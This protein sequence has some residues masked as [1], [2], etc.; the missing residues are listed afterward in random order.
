MDRQIVPQLTSL[1]YVNTRRNR[2]IE[3]RE[4][5]PF[6]FVVTH[7]HR[8]KGT[9]VKGKPKVSFAIP[10]LNRERTLDACLRSIADQDY[11]RTEIIIVDGG[12]T[13]S[14]LKIASKY[15]SKIIHNDGPLGEARQVGVENSNGDIVAIFDSDII[16]PSKNWLAD[17]VQKFHESE[18]VG[19]VWPVNKAPENA[20]V[21]S[22]CYFA[23]WRTRASVFNNSTN[24]RLI[25]G[26]NS[27]VL[28]EALENAGGFNKHLRFGEDL[29]LGS[30]IVKLGYKVVFFDEPLIH[31]TMW[32]LKEYTR[33]QIWGASALAKTRETYLTNL[34][35][36]WSNT[37]RK[38]GIGYCAF[39][40]LELIF[41]GLKGMINGLSRDKDLFW[42]VF[43]ALLSIRVF[44][45]GGF[46]LVRALK[47]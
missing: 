13:D 6:F 36:S 20:S 23:F 8:L 31:D 33:K 7:E 16:I 29:E 38:N 37:S 21:T 42:L 17:A 39:S 22:R 26:G 18:R 40:A 14:T 10:T 34:C 44:V 9:R 47:G 2:P 25:P 19:V 46:F 15:A 27:L 11:P 35:I 3:N 30:R 24:K 4:C 28:R 45:Y 41:T 5:Q 32:S 43:P 12:S 1:G